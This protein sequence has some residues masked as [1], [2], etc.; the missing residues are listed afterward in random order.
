VSQEQDI[1]KRVAQISISFKNNLALQIIH[2]MFYP[3]I[4]SH[5]RISMGGVANLL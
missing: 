2:S 3:E 1:L 5:S 4:I